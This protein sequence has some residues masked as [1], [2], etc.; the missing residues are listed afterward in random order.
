MVV[1]RGRRGVA[2]VVGTVFFVLVFMLAL[3][4][5]AYEA[6]LQQEAAATQEL[7]IQSAS[8]KGDESLA[9]AVTEMGLVATNEGPAT[10]SVNHLV[11]KYPNGTVYPLAASAEL[12]AGGSTLVRSLVPSGVC[13]PGTAT[14]VSEYAQIVAGEDPGSSVGLV[15]GLGNTFW[16]TYEE[17]QVQW[18]SITGFPLPCSAG[19]FIG[20]LNT[21]VTCSAPN[22]LTSWDRVSAS[23]NGTGKYSSTGLSVRLPANRTYAF[24]AFTA[25]EADTGFE[26]YD[27]E[28]HPLAAGAT[29]VIACAPLAYPA[30]GGKS[31]TNCV[32]AAGTPIVPNFG[33]DFSAASPVYETPGLFGVVSGGPSGSPLE[34]DFDCIYNCGGVTMKS[35]SFM[36]VMALG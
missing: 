24:Y 23:T 5:L 4:S 16:Y 15:T 11:L 21:T 2:S 35:G 17:S 30:G 27:F 14:C 3:G 26:T 8:Q 12:P 36:V 10:V 22:G 1:V 33:L 7:A 18:G 9:F 20:G 25:V 29:L 31:P 6:G 34:I 19:E 28:V 13:S 32:S